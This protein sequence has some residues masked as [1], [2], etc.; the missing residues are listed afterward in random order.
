[1]EKRTRQTS[2]QANKPCEAYGQLSA[3][4]AWLTDW[5]SSKRPQT[6]YYAPRVHIHHDWRFNAT[7]KTTS[8]S[9]YTGNTLLRYVSVWVRVYAPTIGSNWWPR[10]VFAGTTNVVDAM[11]SCELLHGNHVVFP[12]HW[13][14][15]D[16]TLSTR[17][18]P[19]LTTIPATMTLPHRFRKRA[20]FHQQS[21]SQSA[22][23]RWTRFHAPL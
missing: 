15:S 8:V 16:S 5:M 7:L 21:M 22:C 14:A 19:I 2:K 1:M 10:P 3:R 6:M 20:W 9:M 17:H 23:S 11:R 4:P 13:D 12:L 18:H